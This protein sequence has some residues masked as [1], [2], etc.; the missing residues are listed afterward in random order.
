[1]SNTKQKHDMDTIKYIMGIYI[2]MKAI[3]SDQLAM[4]EKE[5]DDQSLNYMSGM[6]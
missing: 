1:M 5:V 6:H 4:W 2:G 3:R